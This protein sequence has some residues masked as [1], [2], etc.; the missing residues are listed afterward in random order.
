[1]RIVANIFKIDMVDTKLSRLCL[2]LAVLL[3]CGF[4]VVLVLAAA[5]AFDGSAL[6][7]QG[8]IAADRSSGELAGERG[9]GEWWPCNNII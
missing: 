5:A 7:R 4:I 9:R 6:E 8:L 2:L 3:L 1:M